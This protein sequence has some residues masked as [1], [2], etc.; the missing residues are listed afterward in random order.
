MIEDI[1]KI[2]AAS[3]NVSGI[4]DSVELIAADFVIEEASI[5]RFIEC[6]RAAIERLGTPNQTYLSYQNPVQRLYNSF[7]A[8]I[9]EM[10]ASNTTAFVENMKRPFIE[11]VTQF[12]ASLTI[13]FEKIRGQNTTP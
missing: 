1:K 4:F 5:E 2:S 6:E 10:D 8:V 12:A 11:D 13:E 7:N 3:Y 9:T